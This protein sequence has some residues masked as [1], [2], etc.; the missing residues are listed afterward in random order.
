M[1]S[2][3]K[4]QRTSAAKAAIFMQPCR[5]PEGLLH[6]VV[7]ASSTLR[8]RSS[9]T[10]SEGPASP[11]DPCGPQRSIF[12]QRPAFGLE[13][14]SFLHVAFVT[15]IAGQGH[16]ER[17]GAVADIHRAFQERNGAG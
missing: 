2:D 13:L 1:N 17:T 7:L 9:H 4:R 6:P 5:R 16:V 10:L 3:Y 8:G 11:F 15:V 14:I 12:V